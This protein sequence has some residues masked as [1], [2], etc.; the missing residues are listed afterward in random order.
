MP[1]GWMADYPEMLCKE[2]TV[3]IVFEKTTFLGGK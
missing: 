3:G 1:M 2:P